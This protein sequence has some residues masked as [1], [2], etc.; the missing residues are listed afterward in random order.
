M[1]DEKYCT[2][3]PLSQE[4]VIPAF[5]G[6]LKCLRYQPPTRIKLKH[7]HTVCPF[8]THILSPH[9]G[10]GALPQRPLQRARP[11]PANRARRATQDQPSAA[12]FPR[13]TCAPTSKAD[14]ASSFRNDVF[15]T[16]FGAR[17]SMPS[18]RSAASP[19]SASNAAS[20]S[21]PAKRI[22]MTLAAQRVEREPER[23]TVHGCFHRLPC[24]GDARWLH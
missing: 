24:S 7:W 19:T 21:E 3:T 12:P 9:S 1:G 10:N 14:S 23:Y 13:Q 11:P 20:E 18:L 6:L 5:P 22:S 16:S 8:S 4:L 2:F 15:P 17:A